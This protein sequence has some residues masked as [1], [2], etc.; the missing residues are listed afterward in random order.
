ME[1]LAKYSVKTG[2]VASLDMTS[3]YGTIAKLVMIRKGSKNVNNSQYINMDGKGSDEGESESG[4]D[5]D[6]CYMDCAEDEDPIASPSIATTPTSLRKGEAFL[7]SDDRVDLSNPPR[8][9]GSKTPFD[10]FC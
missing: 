10:F 6:A 1:A 7:S 4:E 2:R 8:I 3:V 5:S 9:P